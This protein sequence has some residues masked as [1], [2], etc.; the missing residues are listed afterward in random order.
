MDHTGDQFPHIRLITVVKNLPL[1]T[2]HTFDKKETMMQRIGE[3]VNLRNIR[4]KVLK[5]CKMQYKVAVD[6]FYVK[7]SNLMFLGWM[8]RSLCCRENEDTLIIPTCAMYISKKSLRS[9]FTGV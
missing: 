6:S 2:G 9:P 8:I 1:M 5:S 3:E 4:V 7:V